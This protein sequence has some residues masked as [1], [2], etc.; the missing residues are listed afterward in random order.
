MSG[1]S[2][3]VA[4]KQKEPSYRSLITKQRDA[5]LAENERLR[6]ALKEAHSR[7]YTILDIEPRAVEEIR[8]QLRAALAAT[9][10]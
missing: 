4:P 9:K 3:L 7:L 5:L 8:V 2:W 6:M 10:G 1:E